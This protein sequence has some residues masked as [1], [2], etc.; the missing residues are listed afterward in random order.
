MRLVVEVRGF[1]SF[2]VHFR[3][4]RR[5]HNPQTGQM[6]A[7]DAKYSP[8]FKP[9]KELRERVNSSRDY[10]QIITDSFGD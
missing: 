8:H 10:T 5:A 1:G 2:K 9:G 6:I 7:T 4:S 3:P